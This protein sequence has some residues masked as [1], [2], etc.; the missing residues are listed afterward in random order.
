MKPENCGREEGN[1]ITPAMTE[2]IFNNE[3]QSLWSSID[4]NYETY[5]YIEI[6]WH[7]E[8]YIRDYRIIIF[9]IKM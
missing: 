7:E 1:F 2:G 9:N 3:L 8:H 6:M 5:N 4:T